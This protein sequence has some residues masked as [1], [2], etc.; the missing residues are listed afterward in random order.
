MLL[1][2]S[3]NR[4]CAAVLAIAAI[5]LVPPVAARA[6]G[7]LLGG[8]KK[9]ATEAVEQ[10]ATQK[11]NQKIDDAA[12][13][14][15]D[16]SF[17]SMFG[18]GDD[19][20]SG[21]KGG[22]KGGR[23]GGFSLLPNAPTE[24]IYDFDAAL[25]YEVVDLSEK[26]TADQTVL[27]TLLFNRAGSYSAVKLAPEQRAKD[28]G[29]LFAIFDVKN[30][31]MVMLM[32]S[33][34][35]K[36]SVAYGWKE[37]KQ[38]SAPPTPQKPSSPGAPVTTRTVP[39]ANPMTFTSLGTRTIAGYKSEGFKGENTDGGAEIWVSRDP[40]LPSGRMMGTVSALRQ[41]R[42]VMPSEYPTGLLMEVNSV[43]KKTGGRGRMTVKSIDVKS[44]TRIDMS[45]YPRLGKAK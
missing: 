2:R 22:S 26:K 16:K 13:K 33:E 27:M 20:K 32:N 11:A 44:K 18:G 14:L 10:R 38:Y 35:D 43:D 30:E 5:A 31:S 3:P 39:D 8:L 29:E 28:D 15:V 41:T 1:L 4:R 36:A 40:R 7:G 42:G 23:L 24:D 21:G 25:T 37:A 9:R 19:G 6:Q 12:R 45:E 17:D 34:K